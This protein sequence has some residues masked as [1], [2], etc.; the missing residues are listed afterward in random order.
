MN[1]KKW[2]SDDDAKLKLYFNE[3]KNYS[4]IMDE[5]GRTRKSIHSRARF[6][7]IISKHMKLYREQVLLKT[8]NKR[9]C[10][11]CKNVFDIS[12]FYGKDKRCK[13]CACEKSKKY[14]WSVPPEQ[15]ISD[16]WKEAKY[17]AEKRGLDFSI[18][19]DDIKNQFAFQKGRCFYTN[20]PL[21]LKNG[22]RKSNPFS[23]SI[24]RV[25]S[26]NGY[27]KSNIV[28]CGKIINSMKLD[29]DLSN[30]I[31]LCKKISVFRNLDVGKLSENIS[32]F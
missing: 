13:P 21:E 31:E 30:F 32:V 27:T 19:I 12:D 18:T 11:I 10:I 20:E 1:H 26:K 28:L 29:L 3:G 5:L 24:D 6:L 25:D 22:T 2:S 14:R 4:F 9:R 23:M 17:R 15:I 7:G 16:R 8:Q